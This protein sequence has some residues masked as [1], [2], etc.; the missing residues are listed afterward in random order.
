MKNKPT[1]EN[2][3]D[4]SE[5]WFVKLE[6][7][8]ENLLQV[9]KILNRHDISIK[10]FISFLSYMIEHNQSYAHVFDVVLEEIKL[11][12]AN[13]QLEIVA[14]LKKGKE[15]IFNVLKSHDAFKNRKGNL[16][17][18]ESTNG[19]QNQKGNQ[20]QSGGEEQ[21]SKDQQEYQKYLELLK[22]YEQSK[23]DV[24]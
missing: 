9:K 10:E 1:V 16:I 24:E 11:L 2:L 13:D 5:R 7:S 18:N 14:A 21:P 23:E 3:I 22:K 12:K 8:V 15:N 6:F 17:I 19:N 20:S 4:F